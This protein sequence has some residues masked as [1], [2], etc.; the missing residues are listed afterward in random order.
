M[1]NAIVAIET[2]C[3]PVIGVISKFG[4]LRELHDVMGVEIPSALATPNTSVVVVGEHGLLPIPI[5][6]P[7][8]FKDVQFFLGKEF[9]SAFGLDV[10]FTNLLAVLERLA[11]AFPI[12]VIHRISRT[13][14]RTESTLT[15]ICFVLPNLKCLAATLTDNL[16]SRLCSV[17]ICTFQGTILPVKPGPAKENHPALDT[18]SLDPRHAALPIGIAFSA[19]VKVSF[20]HSENFLA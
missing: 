18:G 13:L 9:V 16:H 3:H 14:F 8:T 7:L 15:S 6:H 11:F 19:L 1:D 2:K 10:G 4:I 12:T 20:A 5:P 17:S